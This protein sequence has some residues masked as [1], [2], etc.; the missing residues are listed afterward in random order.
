MEEFNQ[1]NPT[2]NWSEEEKY[3]FC[4]TENK[5]TKDLKVKNSASTAGKAEDMSLC[6]L[7]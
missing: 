2:I 7:F 4:K 1:N 6:S 3:D 5:W